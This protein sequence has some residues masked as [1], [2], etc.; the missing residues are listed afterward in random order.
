MASPHVRSNGAAGPRPQLPAF[1]RSRRPVV[2]VTASSI[3][4]LRLLVLLGLVFQL[5]T[6]LLLIAGPVPPLLSPATVT[7]HFRPDPSSALNGPVTASPI[8]DR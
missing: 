5:S 8:S 1:C 4:N 6:L 7:N 2:M 3:A